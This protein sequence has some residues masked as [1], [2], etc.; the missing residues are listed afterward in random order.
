MLNASSLDDLARKIG[1]A[2]EGSPIKDVE[3]N[4]K[5]ML[6]GGLEHLDLVSRHEFDIQ[7]QLLA[8][9][10]EKL[11]ALEARVAELERRAIAAN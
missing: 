3:K 1:R 11:D 10:R 8:H 7:A 4:V 6:Q 9:T 2:I 5:A